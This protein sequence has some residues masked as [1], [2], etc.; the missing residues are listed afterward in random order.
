MQWALRSELF[1]T[2]DGRKGISG[3]RNSKRKAGWD[4]WEQKRMDS[5]QGHV[6]SRGLGY[7]VSG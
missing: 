3:K 7:R 6:K 2:C 5:S 4:G 1:G